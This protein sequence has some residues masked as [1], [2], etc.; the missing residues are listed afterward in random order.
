MPRAVSRQPEEPAP[1]TEV[2][3]ATFEEVIFNRVGLIGKQVMENSNKL[4]KIVQLIEEQIN[5]EEK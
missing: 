3:I 4:D 5:P 1:K 2:Q